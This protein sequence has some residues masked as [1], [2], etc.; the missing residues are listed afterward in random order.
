[1]LDENVMT[2][3]PAP[4]AF[5]GENGAVREEYV[6]RVTRAIGD[7]TTAAGCAGTGS[8]PL[9]AASQTTPTAASRT[10]SFMACRSQRPGT[11]VSC[12]VSGSFAVSVSS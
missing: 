3:E 7:A 10:T 6:D 4:V 1:M 8:R 2:A 11:G 9:H 12:L 5:R